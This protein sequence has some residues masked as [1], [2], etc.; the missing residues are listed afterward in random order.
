MARIAIGAATLAAGR[1]GIAHV[2][3][4]SAA[5]LIAAGHEVSLNAYLDD[6]PAAI[7]GTRFSATARGGKLR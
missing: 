4:I 3:R 1:G 6:A 5:A 2:A 7:A